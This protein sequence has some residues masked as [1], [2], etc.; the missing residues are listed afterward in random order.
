MYFLT[1]FLTVSALAMLNIVGAQDVI[2][3]ERI[4]HTIIPQS[5]YLVDRTT[6]IVWTQGPSIS[7]TD[8]ATPTATT[9]V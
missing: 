5:P 6:T 4:Y 2:T 9:T 8:T 1:S 7:D 3:A